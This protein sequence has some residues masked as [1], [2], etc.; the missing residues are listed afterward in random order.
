MET[1]ESSNGGTPLNG[2]GPVTG[3]PEATKKKEDSWIGANVSPLLALVTVIM[4]FMMFWGFIQVM[5]T[6]V[7]ETG[8]LYSAQDKYD[9][10]LSKLQKVDSTQIEERMR[11]N[12]EIKVLQENVAYAKAALEESKEQRGVVKDI[13]LYILGVLSSTITTIFSYYF[14]SSKSSAQKDDTLNEMS[15]TAAGT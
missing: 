1:Q 6:P 4:T 13:I 7:R 9:T 14:G 12:E 3:K 10:A 11:I 5:K 8:K 2:D 15:R